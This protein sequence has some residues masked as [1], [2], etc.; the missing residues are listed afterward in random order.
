[1]DQYKTGFGDVGKA[2]SNLRCQGWAKV[3]NAFLVAYCRH[4]MQCNIHLQIWFV[5][6]TDKF[7]KNQLRIQLQVIGVCKSKGC[8]FE[9][10]LIQILDGNGLKAMTGSIPTPNSGSFMEK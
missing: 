2:W 6:D 9:S 3:K 4:Y 5:P 1:M 7:G 10:R 8:G